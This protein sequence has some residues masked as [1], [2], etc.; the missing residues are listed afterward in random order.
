MKKTIKLVLILFLAA[1][2]VSCGNKEDTYDT[3]KKQHLNENT[4][5]SKARGEYYLYFYK[6]NCPP[7]LSIKELTFAQARS[8]TTK[9]YFINEKDVEDTLN[10]T[11]QSDYSNVGA[12]NFK[13][14]KILGFPTL[15]LIKDGVVVKQFVG[16]TDIRAELEK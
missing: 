1:F 10:R 12:E 11:D 15:F 9:L 5:F 8:K 16:S 3:F 4:A 14:L 2:L 13:S 6:E 7:C